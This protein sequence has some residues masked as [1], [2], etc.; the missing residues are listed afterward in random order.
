[1]LKGFWFLEG[2]GTDDSVI[3]MIYFHQ[4]ILRVSKWTLLDLVKVYVLH[5][6]L[7]FAISVCIFVMPD[8]HTYDC[9][10]KSIPNCDYYC[11]AQALNAVSLISQ[12]GPT[13]DDNQSQKVTFV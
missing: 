13:D 8:K 12:P 4:Q 7:H 3:V 10:W 6:V 11:T 5:N 1:M 2:G 9:S